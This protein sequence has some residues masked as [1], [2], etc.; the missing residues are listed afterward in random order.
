[1][2][3]SRSFLKLIQ[4][5]RLVMREYTDC[6]IT[7]VWKAFTFTKV[8]PVMLKNISVVKHIMPRSQLLGI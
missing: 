3:F 4:F 8:K 2:D 5:Q 7:V 1:L 6:G